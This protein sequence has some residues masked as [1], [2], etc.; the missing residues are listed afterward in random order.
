MD[1]TF[2]MINNRKLTS[3]QNTLLNVATVENQI[4]LLTLINSIA[5]NSSSGG[6]GIKSIQRG[7]TSA[8]GKVTINAVDVNKS[9]L[10]SVS[11]ASAGTV[12]AR[13][14]VSM[15]A[16]S[17][18]I[19]QTGTSSQTG[20]NPVGYSSAYMTNSFSGTVAAHTG[21]LSGGTTDLTVKVYSAVLTNS[22]TITC[23]GAVEW[24]LVEYL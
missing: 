11:K 15:A 2:D 7:V 23:D 3:I 10:Y 5:N 16:A 12:A 1:N 17:V 24:Q 4:E 8:A 9:F 14:T 6:G 19:S 13:G 18:S 20:V 21:T 22:T